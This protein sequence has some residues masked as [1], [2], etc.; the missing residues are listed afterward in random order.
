METGNDPVHARHDGRV[1][2]FEELVPYDTSLIIVVRTKDFHST[3]QLLELED[4]K[5]WPGAEVR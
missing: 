5:F 4:I 1:H 2:S 3:G